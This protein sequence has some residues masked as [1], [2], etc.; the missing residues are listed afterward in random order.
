M[1]TTIKNTLLVALM[2]GTLISYATEGTNPANVAVAKRVKVEFNAVKKGQTLSIK[3]ENGLTIYTQDIK[4]SGVYSKIFDLTALEDGYYT[5]ELEKDFEVIVKKIQVKDGVVVSL[6]N[7]TKIFKPVVRTQDN[8]LLI[9]KLCLDKQPLKITLYYKNRIL[10]S[11]TLN[12]CE[13]IK[14]VYKLSESEKGDYRV[15]IST[16]KRMY[17]KD[18]II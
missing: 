17:V 3:N 7:D 16:D 9:S 11:E 2:L 5:T 14:R 10:I 18:F 12:E 15:V 4:E 1:R 13:L 6:E 8:L